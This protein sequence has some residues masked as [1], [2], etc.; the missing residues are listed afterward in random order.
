MGG[1]YGSVQVRS[2]DRDQVKKVAEQVA[3]S[4]GIKCLVGP[5][6]RNWVGIYP[7][8]HGQDHRFGEEIAQ[9][10][11]CEVFHIIVYDDDIMAYWLWR[12]GDLVDAYWSRPGYFGEQQ[13]QEEEAMIG[14]PEVYGNL[15]RGGIDAVRELLRRD[16]RVFSIEQKRLGQFARLLNIANAVTSYEYLNEGETEEIKG[17]KNFEELPADVIAKEKKEALDEHRLRTALKEQ[18][19]A[20]AVS[21]GTLLAEVVRDHGTSF[22][23]AVCNGF[24]VPYFD[25]STADIRSV[26]E[27]YT[28]PWKQP[29]LVRINL[30]GQINGMAGDSAGHRLAVALGNR[31]AV[32]D[33]RDWRLLRR[34]PEK[35]QAIA[36]ALGDDGRLLAHA[37][38]EEVVVTD[39]DTGTRVSMLPWKNARQVA[40]HPSGKVLIAVFEGG[41]MEM[42]DLDEQGAKQRRKLSIKSGDCHCIKF[43]RDGQWLCCRAGVYSWPDVNANAGNDVLETTWR[44]TD[45]M[46]SVY[47]GAIVQE[48][49]GSGIVFSGFDGKISRL[50]LASGDVRG[51]LTMPG[52]DCIRELAMS[53]DGQ[54]LGVLSF[55]V[56]NE[57]A[58]S[59]WSYPRLVANA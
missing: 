55:S 42:V 51:L 23:C 8:H 17:W 20:Q 19:R 44:Y 1:F 30:T 54:V 6:L 24:V 12:G 50:D 5:V 59:I 9:G 27:Y 13:R 7:E 31:A 21:A 25:L 15:L 58:W 32:W 28:S 38:R 4:A 57:R 10:L 16:R 56:S 35:N 26:L 53:P 49:A 29:T 2:E 3:R 11:D 33:A 36:V 47:A 14:R 43:T 40:F 39:V 52:G 37:S 48:V 18:A 45:E 22:V 46:T 34:V 41:V